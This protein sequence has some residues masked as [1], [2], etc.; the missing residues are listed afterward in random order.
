M[1]FEA[2]ICDIDGCLG[3]ESHAPFHAEHLVTLAKHNR[4]AIA[5]RRRGDVGAKPIVTLC[6]G[7]PQPFAE[8][9]CRVIGNDELPCIA[10][11]G[12]WIYDPANN[13]FEI[14]PAIL[15]EHRAWVRGATA[16]I[17][18]RL[19]PNGVVI[20]PGKTCSISIWHP[21]TAYLMAQ[22]PVLGKFFESQGWKLRVSNS[23]EW[24]NCDLAHVSKA[25]GITR[26]TKL[27]GITSERL[28]GIG[29][30][31][32][33]MAIRRQVRYFATPANAEEGLKAHADYVSPYRDIEGVLDILERIS[34]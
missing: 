10:E 13:R 16:F 24:V 22:K 14:D 2:V 15:P 21:D 11:M 31:M 4:V 32:G 3:P 18:D 34:R 7:R 26:F 5:E 9:L 1:R 19:V 29:D 33:D 6:S 17:E 28:A 27:T 30:T 8:A 25:E 23:V 20:Q 12:V